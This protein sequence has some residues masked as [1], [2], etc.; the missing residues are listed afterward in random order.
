MSADTEK[1]VLGCDKCQCYKPAAHPP[2]VLQPQ[3]TPNG[4]WEHVGVD[5]ITQLPTSRGYTAIVVFV[6]HFSD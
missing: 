4:S 5:L 1:Y 3:E 6:D 2:A